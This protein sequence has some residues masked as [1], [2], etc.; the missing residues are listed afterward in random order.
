MSGNV[1]IDAQ[2]Q[3]V[4]RAEEAAKVAREAHSAALQSY[5]SVAAGATAGDADFEK[6]IVADAAAS[7]ATA[8]AIV[9]AAHQGLTALLTPAGKSSHAAEELPLF[10]DER[11]EDQPLAKRR[12]RDALT[13]IAR[14]LQA[15]D[16]GWVDDFGRPHAQR[17]RMFKA[18]S[19]RHKWLWS[20]VD[21]VRCL[22]IQSSIDATHPLYARAVQALQQAHEAA[23]DLLDQSMQ[24]F[25]YLRVLQAQGATVANLFIGEDPLA[26]ASHAHLKRLNWSCKQARQLAS[27]KNAGGVR[28]RNRQ[29]PRQRNERGSYGSMQPPQ[30]GAYSMAMPYGPMYAS[31]PPPAPP[32][33]NW[34]GS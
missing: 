8:E 9:V 1:S 25:L 17:V 5:R 2:R 18:L 13:D 16:C 12:K 24:E 3:E 20:V 32:S 34:Q 26:D 28:G 33:R 27:A 11:D 10:P 21:S 31:P 19:R 6:Q 30:G 7:K 29:R 22:A 14:E 4:A 15:P 23:H